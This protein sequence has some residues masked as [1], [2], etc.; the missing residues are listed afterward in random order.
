MSPGDGMLVLIDTVRQV[1]C[2]V[3][4]QEL[5]AFTQ[6]LPLEL[7]AVTLMLSVPCPEL[8][9]HPEGTFQVYETAP[10]TGVT[11]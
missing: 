11:E 3:R 8:M 1:G 7:P 4:L 10:G 2:E 6:M 5:V 9:T